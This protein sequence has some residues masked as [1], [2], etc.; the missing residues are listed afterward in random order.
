MPWKWACP[1]SCEDSEIEEERPGVLD[2]ALKDATGWIN[3]A[4]AHN[5]IVRTARGGGGGALL[6]SIL[7]KCS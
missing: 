4:R 2:D 7:M 3:L 1:S 5:K 6:D